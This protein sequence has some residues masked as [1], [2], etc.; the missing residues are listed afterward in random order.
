M[1]LRRSLLSH[2]EFSE[3]KKVVDTLD[4]WL[5]HDDGANLYSLAKQATGKGVI[6]EI[7]SWKGK[8][9]VC[10]AKGSKRGNNIPVYA[11]DPHSGSP[12]HVQEKGHI[13]TFEE[14]KQNISE[15]EVEDLVVAIVDTSQHAALDFDRPVEVIF[16][17]GAHDY[18][19][20]KEDFDLWYPK[21]VDGG[22]MAFHDSVEP[23]WPGVVEVVDTHVYKS[24]NFKNIHMVGVTTYA[25]KSSDIS[26][27]DI[28]KNRYVLLIKTVARRFTLLPIPDAVAQVA[29]KI[30]QYIQF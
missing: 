10:L 4:G 17:D 14:F 3:I 11:I 15:A 22:W 6:V 13:A 18:D 27:L 30:Y 12:E 21:V 2:E 19:S 24:N 7:G 25:Q 16:V 20:V 8:S 1:K 5:S 29:K 28:F 26:W 23:T 9:T